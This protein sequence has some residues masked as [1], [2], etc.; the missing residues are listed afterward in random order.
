MDQ[1]LCVAANHVQMIYPIHTHTKPYIP[2]FTNSLTNDFLNLKLITLHCKP[3]ARFMIFP[4]FKHSSTCHHISL[5]VSSLENNHFKQGILQ[6][7][8]IKEFLLSIMYHLVSLMVSW[9]V[10]FMTSFIDGILD[11]FIHGFLADFLDSFMDDIPQECVNYI[12][13]CFFR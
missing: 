1:V 6:V 10:S 7:S 8:C 13:R 11:G 2:Y 5:A 9:I 3:S 4:S 12:P